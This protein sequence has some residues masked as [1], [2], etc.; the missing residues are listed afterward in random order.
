M[1][2]EAKRTQPLREQRFLFVIF[3]KRQIMLMNRSPC[4]A[5][6]LPEY[7]LFLE[8]KNSTWYCVENSCSPQVRDQAVEVGM[9]SLTSRYPLTESCFLPRQLCFG[10][11][12]IHPL[13]N[14]VMAPL[15]WKHCDDDLA[16]LGT[17]L[18]WPNRQR[19][20]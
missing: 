19:K 7:G 6:Q 20:K 1:F 17:I 8:L 12:G 3:V 10:E 2:H 13:R 18:Q 9:A 14:S 4:F 5:S 11:W 16:T 15:N